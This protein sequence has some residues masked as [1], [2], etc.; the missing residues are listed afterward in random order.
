[1][2]FVYV[3]VE[4]VG[5]AEFRVPFYSHVKSSLDWKIMYAR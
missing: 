3:C 5:L 2:C 4:C 1:M